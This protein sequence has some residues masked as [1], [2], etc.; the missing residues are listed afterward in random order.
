L[1][2]AIAVSRIGI[3]PDTAWK[4]HAIVFGGALV[5]SFVCVLVVLASVA[6]GLTRGRI[7][8]GAVVSAVGGP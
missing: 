7:R 2:W 6:W 3:T 1:P 8:V 5:V 4:W